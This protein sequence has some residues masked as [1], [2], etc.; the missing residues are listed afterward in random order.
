VFIFYVLEITMSQQNSASLNRIVIVVED[1]RVKAIH[2][3]RNSPVKIAVINSGTEIGEGGAETHAL[4]D[5]TRFDGGLEDPLLLPDKV[6]EVFTA[7]DW[8][9]SSDKTRELRYLNNYGDTCPVCDSSDLSMHQP[10]G[11]DNETCVCDVECH[12]CQSCWT[13]VYKLDCYE[14]LSSDVL[15]VGD[16]GF[17]VNVNLTPIQA[18]LYQSIVIHGVKERL[19]HDTL[20]ICEVDEADPAFFSVYLRD[21]AGISHC[22]GDCGKLKLPVLRQLAESLANEH[23]WSF[24]DNTAKYHPSEGWSGKLIG[25]IALS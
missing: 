2:T 3:E 13:N 4:A 14:D 16:S 8:Q 9:T 5:G 19:T 15:S 11:L 20:G 24:I 22:V 25:S 17:M 23:G 18:G 6:A 12:E 7:F 21:L 1:G 10:S